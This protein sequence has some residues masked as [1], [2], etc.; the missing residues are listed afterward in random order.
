[1]HR[2]TSEMKLGYL[3]CLTLS[4]AELIPHSFSSR[5]AYLYP[6]PRPSS[7]A[8]FNSFQQQHIH[9]FHRNHTRI[10][11]CNSKRHP[12]HKTPET[13]TTRDLTWISTSQSNVPGGQDLSQTD[14]VDMSRSDTAAPPSRRHFIST[15]RSKQVSRWATCNAG[16]ALDRGGWK[17]R[18]CIA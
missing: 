7:I 5:Q 16:T 10:P 6:P 9:S 17:T 11:P 1:M 13:I 12:S 18:G 14:E 2:A 3:L 4:Q 8:L 15:Q